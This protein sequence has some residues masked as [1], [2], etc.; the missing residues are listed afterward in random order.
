MADSPSHWHRIEAV[1]LEALEHPPEERAAFLNEACA[2]DSD[3]RAEVEALLEAHEAGPVAFEERMT[4]LRGIV[5]DVPEGAL[6]QGTRLGSYRIDGLLG[7][8]GMG[9]VYRAFDLGLEREVAIKTLPAAVADDPERL[10]RFVREGKALAS[11]RHPG[12]VTVYAVEEADGVH[13]LAMELLEGETLADAIPEGGMSLD[14]FS[15]L[16]LQL[17]EALTAVHDRGIVHRD[18]K[19]GNVMVD[20]EG[21]AILLDFGLVKRETPHGGRDDDTLAEEE[22]TRT[23]AVMGTWRYMSPEQARGEEVD[24]RSDVFSLGVV[25]YEMLSGASPFHRTSEAEIVAAILHEREPPLPESRE[26]VPAALAHVVGRCLEKEREARYSSAE[27]VAEALRSALETDAASAKGPGST[28]PFDARWLVAAAA[29]ITA[30]ATVAWLTTRGGGR[31]ADEVPHSESAPTA[32]ASLLGEIDPLSIAVL[33]FDNLSPDPDNAFF[34]DGMTEEMISRLSQIG[35]LTVVSRT[36]V[37]RF[38]QTDL[39]ARQIAEDLNVANILEG[40]VRRAGGQVRITGQLIDA[41]SDRHLWSDSYTREL[42]DVFAVQSDVASQ[43]AAAL[44]LELSSGQRETLTRAPTKSATAYDFYLKGMQ[45]HRRFREEDNERAIELFERA[46]E[47]DPD[48]ALAYAGL[49]GSYSQRWQRFAGDR[50][51]AYQLS[52]GAAQQAVRLAPRLAEAH[53]ALA[54]AYFAGGRNEDSCAALR[55][56]VELKPSF[57][58]AIANIGVICAAYRQQWAEALRQLKRAVRLDP[59]DAHLATYVGYLL[60]DVDLHAAAEPWFERALELEPDNIPSL[61]YPAYSHLFAG[62]ADAAL[63]FA[64]RI[65]EVAPEEAIGLWI[66]ATASWQNGDVAEA[67]RLAERAPGG[68]SEFLGAPAAHIAWSE[69]RFEDARALLRPTLDWLE[70]APEPSLNDLL[71]AAEAHAIQEDPEQAYHYLEKALAEGLARDGQLRY[72]P[73]FEKLREQDRFRQILDRVDERIAQQRREVEQLD[74]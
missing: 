2:S 34:A 47:E 12:V 64:H 29:L 57:R 38:K 19:P 9:D 73:S 67:K 55:R 27:E 74:G 18:L 59:L 54:N 23:G 35:V 26:D 25:L 1:F 16:G 51:A 15:D 60:T 71:K 17:T 53:N 69:G 37:M 63:G 56:A 39:S 31:S 50:Q 42:A 49:G 20:E 28:S 30:F 32:S 52:L 22:R 36:S 46:L 7:R 40:S 4:A 65:L 14:R 66:A 13:F 10:A 3:R 8:G 62:E 21:R 68:P 70:Q 61:A 72:Y 45:Y 5:A 24:V 41:R 43:I 44:Q 33:P 6:S 48:F 11:V 58:G